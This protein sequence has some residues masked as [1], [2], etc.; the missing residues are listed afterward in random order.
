MS[1]RRSLRIAE[2]EKRMSTK[3]KL[4]KKIITGTTL[5]RYNAF[6]V[7]INLTNIF[8]MF[9]FALFVDDD[10]TKQCQAF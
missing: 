9:T 8:E 3:I 7:D 10:L 5:K 1:G 2:S 6:N 4:R